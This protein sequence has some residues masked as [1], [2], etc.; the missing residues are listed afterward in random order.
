MTVQPS[1]CFVV[2]CFNEEDNVAP[3]VESIRTAAG[4][5]RTFEIVLV[6][7]CSTDLTL[8]RMQALAQADPRIRVLHNPVNLSLGGAYKRGVAVAEADYV[9]MIPG[10]DGFPADSI[11]E[12]IR[13]A[14]KADIIIP[15]VTNSAVRTWYRAV[16]SKGFTTLLNWLFWLNVGYYNGAVLHRT[17]LLRTIDIKT[18]SF[19]YQAE[20]LV[21]LIA[22]GATHIHCYVSIQERAA[23]RSSAL[24]VRNQ[25]EV[26]RTIIHLV[27]TVG[28]FRRLRIG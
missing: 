9:T 25:V 5:E 8:E 20:A 19:A 17:A 4:P 27:T 6:D 21:K 2:P 24:S 23:G 28:I 14:G 26:W 16:A 11:A 12:I 13:Q 15:V 10:D 7:D 1:I 18:N 3:T 22:R